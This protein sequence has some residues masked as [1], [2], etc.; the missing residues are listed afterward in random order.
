[1]IHFIPQ[2]QSPQGLPLEEVSNET[3]H[4]KYPT[5]I[6]TPLQID[7]QEN[8]LII[9]SHLEKLEEEKGKCQKEYGL[10]KMHPYISMNYYQSLRNN[11]SLKGHS[12]T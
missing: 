4:H 7:H 11:N 2:V 9:R 1:M 6:S 8:P 5:Q 10:L 3:H 12:L